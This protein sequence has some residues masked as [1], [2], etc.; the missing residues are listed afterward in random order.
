M[1]LV[2][3]AFNLLLRDDA[4]VSALVNDRVYNSF[5]PQ[6]VTYPY[7]VTRAEGRS[8]VITLNGPTGLRETRM[9]VYSVA[10]TYAEAKEL[11]EA[12]RLASEG[13][14]GIIAD[15]TSPSNTLQVQLIHCVFSQD[16]YVEG[17]QTGTGTKA[18]EI[19]TDYEVTAH[20][21]IPV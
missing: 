13:Y 17:S 19:V 18:H 3:M 6:T 21:E 2:E 9:R 10:R 12:V 1:L 20:E 4:G 8:H 11:D 14:Q 7:V 5:A 16:E 15:D